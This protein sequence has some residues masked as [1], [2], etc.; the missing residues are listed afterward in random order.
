M[1]L[2]IYLYI[3]LIIFLFISIF[4][5]T[6]ENFNVFEDKEYYVTGNSINNKSS[7]E[8]LVTFHSY[9]PVYE[10]NPNYN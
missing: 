7:K 1:K 10:L 8:K 9:A 3:I 2:K 4:F 6:Y 5:S